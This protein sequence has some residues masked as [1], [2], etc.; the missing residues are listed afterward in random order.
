MTAAGV[1]RVISGPLLLLV[2]GILPDTR[3]VLLPDMELQ[4]TNA[5]RAKRIMKET[6]VLTALLADSHTGFTCSIHLRPEHT[7]F[8]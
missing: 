4:D 2:F 3:P 6:Q 1:M 5:Q 8:C 7:I